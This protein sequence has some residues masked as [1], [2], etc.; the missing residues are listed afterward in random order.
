MGAAKM[1]VR[2]SSSNSNSSTPTPTP[3]TV[4]SPGPTYHNLPN[5]APLVSPILAYATSP[6]AATGPFLSTP[7]ANHPSFSTSEPSPF[8]YSTSTAYPSSNPYATHL[9]TL[10]ST[11]IS[12]SPYLSSL[13]QTLIRARSAYFCPENGPFEGSYTKGVL[14]PSRPHI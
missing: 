14:H 11:P 8:V 9:A 10:I 5:L 4:N 3:T 13:S 12:A 1:I 2:P 7:G 6:G